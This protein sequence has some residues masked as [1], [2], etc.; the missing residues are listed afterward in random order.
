MWKL[1][2][3]KECFLQPAKVF[4]LSINLTKQNHKKFAKLKKCVIVGCSKC[5]THLFN[6]PNWQLFTASSVINRDRC[7]PSCK[8]QTANHLNILKTRQQHGRHV[9]HH[10]FDKHTKKCQEM[11][12]HP[13][14]SGTTQILIKFTERGEESCCKFAVYSTGNYSSLGA[15][16][17]VS[18]CYEWLSGVCYSKGG[19]MFL[20]SY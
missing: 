7:L 1:L 10:C 16:L 2:V 14:P 6:C 4:L 13:Q 15:S 11:S 12:P 8:I 3:Y 17:F 9:T 5:Y 18:A 19:K 20:F